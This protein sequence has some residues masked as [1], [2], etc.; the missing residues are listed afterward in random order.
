MSEQTVEQRAAEIRVRWLGKYI[1]A[2][3]PDGRVVVGELDR[4]EVIAGQI[5]LFGANNAIGF[6]L[7]NQRGM[8]QEL[9]TYPPVL[10]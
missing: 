8:I 1:E 7:D 3:N 10:H 2:R 5:F 6:Q 9:G 4:V